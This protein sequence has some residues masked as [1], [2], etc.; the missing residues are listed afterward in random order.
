MTY[1]TLSTVSTPSQTFAPE[2]Y[3]GMTD[4]QEAERWLGLTESQGVGDVITEDL[5]E[6][7]LTRDYT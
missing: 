7:G 5:T 3:I 6:L 2:P 1:A 4:E